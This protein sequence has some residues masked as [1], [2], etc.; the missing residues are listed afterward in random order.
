MSLA[1]GH[2]LDLQVTPES[3]HW[4]AMSAPRSAGTSTPTALRIIGV[5]LSDRYFFLQVTLSAQGAG[6]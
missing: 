3:R 5:P 1:H 6:S 4:L 2:L